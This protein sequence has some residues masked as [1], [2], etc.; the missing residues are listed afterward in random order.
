M[1]HLRL[2][3]GFMEATTAS[4]LGGRCQPRAGKESRP[5]SERVGLKLRGRKWFRLRSPNEQCQF[6]PVKRSQQ[7]NGQDGPRSSDRRRRPETQ[8]SESAAGS[9]SEGYG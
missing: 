9:T 6:L 5:L 7:H 3:R 2:L 4:T 1:Q 8:A